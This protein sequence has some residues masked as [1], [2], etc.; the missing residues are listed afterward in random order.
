[1]VEKRQEKFSLRASAAIQNVTIRHFRQ[2][3]RC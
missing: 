1:M 3:S 2:I